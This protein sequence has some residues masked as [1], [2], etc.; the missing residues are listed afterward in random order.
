MRAG[1]KRRER[2]W[3]TIEAMIDL[4]CRDQH[5]PRSG[6]CPECADLAAYARQRLEKCPFEDEKPTCVKCPIHCYKP[7]CREQVRQVMRYAGPRM[8]LHRPLLAIRHMLDEHK[9]APARRRRA[10]GRRTGP[11]DATRRG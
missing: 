6:L 2:E 8:L 1:S 3:R 5:G 9:P 10:P 4:F 11:A 7:A